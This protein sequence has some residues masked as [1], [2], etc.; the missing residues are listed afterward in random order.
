M[1]GVEAGVASARP[2]PRVRLPTGR[3]FCS[4][5]R[6]EPPPLA[7]T[8]LSTVWIGGDVTDRQERL[9]HHRDSHANDYCVVLVGGRTP[10]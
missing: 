7:I 6:A 10:L 2:V 3:A 1:D 9:V 4:F 5:G 8:P